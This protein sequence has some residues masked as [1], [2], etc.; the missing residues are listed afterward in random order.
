MLLL[1]IDNTILPSIP[2]YEYAL[3][4]LSKLWAKKTGGRIKDFSAIFEK[5]RSETKKD[6]EGHSSNRLR[7]LY[8]KKMWDMQK[9]TLNS[10]SLENILEFEEKYF[11]YFQEYVEEFMSNHK[12]EYKEVWKLLARIQENQRIIF[13]SN[14]NLRTQLLKLLW[15]LPK[16]IQF[17]LLVSE[18]LGIEKPNKKLFSRA[19]EMGGIKAKQPCHII[20]DS[21]E[22]DIKGGASVGLRLIHQTSIWGDRESIEMVGTPSTIKAWRTKNLLTSLELVEENR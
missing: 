9:G 1:D 5:A 2:A 3:K 21:W 6:L 15:V 10:K 14:E 8:F 11:Y 4:N 18:E 7:I 17:K 19:I 22:D 16:E 20:G 13:I 12:K